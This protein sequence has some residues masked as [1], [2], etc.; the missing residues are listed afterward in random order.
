MYTVLFLYIILSLFL[1]L[2]TLFSGKGLR[3]RMYTRIQFCS[4]YVQ[5]HSGERLEHP[6]PAHWCFFY[7]ERNYSHPW[8]PVSASF[9]ILLYVLLLLVLGNLILFVFFLDLELCM[10]VL[11]FTNH[12]WRCKYNFLYLSLLFLS[13]WPLM[14]DPQGQALK[15][16]KK[17]ELS[18]VRTGFFLSHQV[19]GGNITSSNITQNTLL[20]F[21]WLP[22]KV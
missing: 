4:F 13:R 2:L 18:K 9:G 16:I 1:Y 8:K 12:V 10:Y 14:V 21:V 19:L 22:I 11:H 20:N 17:M 6:G 7:W 3:D 5:T 15:W